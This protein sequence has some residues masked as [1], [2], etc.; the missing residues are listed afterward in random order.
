MRKLYTFGLIMTGTFILFSFSTNP[1]DGYTGAPGDDFC[2]QCHAHTNP[3]QN[4]TISVEGFPDV[5]TPHE[6]YILTAVNRLTVDTAVRG[7][8]QVTILGPTN[9]KAGDFTNPSSKSIVST[10]GGRQYWEH[11][12]ALEYP[13]SNVVKWTVEWTAPELAP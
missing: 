4:G 1:P 8:F 3:S 6:T 12:P 9:T 10:Q 5:I 7:G 13:D 2:I 11:N